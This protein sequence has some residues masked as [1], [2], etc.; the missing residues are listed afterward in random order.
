MILEYR[1]DE[2]PQV[3]EQFWRAVGAA[4]VFAFNGPMGAG[5]T[6]TIAALCAALGVR[7]AVSSPT[8]P[9]I[10]EYVYEEAGLRRTLYHLDLYRLRDANEAIAAGVEDCLSSGS[11]C[12]VEW[13]ERAPGLLEDALAI[14][15][16]VV[17]GETRRLRLG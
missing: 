4:R 10:N 13:P 1:L 3:A 16:E 6:T 12:F 17:D 8:F 2:L 14:E 11:V 15:L 7:E 9:I 5:K